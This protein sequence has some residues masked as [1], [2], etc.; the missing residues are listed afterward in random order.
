M[1]PKPEGAVTVFVLGLLGLLI[2][3]PLGIAA[4]IMGNSYMAKCRAM[5]VQ[6]EG[7]AVAGRIL[8]MIAT[9]LMILAVVIWVIVICA[10]GA[11]VGWPG[12]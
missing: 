1:E 8:G 11:L 7:L 9:C 12:A 4:W 5:L 3:A 2:C 10:G 6:P